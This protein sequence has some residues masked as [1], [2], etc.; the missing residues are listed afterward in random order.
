MPPKKGTSLFEQRRLQN[1]AANQEILKD[2]SHT[3][4]KI[5]KPAPTPKP[6]RVKKAPVER[7][8][9]PKR[10]AA[11]ATRA[12][13]RLKGEDPLKREAEDDI[14]A[15][16]LPAE[17]PAK[18]LRVADDLSLSD[19]LVDGRKFAADVS[20]LSGLLPKRGAEPGVRTFDEDDIRQTTDK[21]LKRLREEMNGLALY[22][23]W[24]VNGKTIPS[25]HQTPPPPVTAAR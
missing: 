2:I 7:R 3:A 22:E 10:E 21:D 15:S 24:A 17:R 8:E 20:S 19:V 14:P 5:A 25:S 16:L 4:A 18:K 13:S 1:I 23:K 11:V 6:P 9:R 12:S